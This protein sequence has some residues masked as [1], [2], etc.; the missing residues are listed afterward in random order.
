MDSPTPSLAQLTSKPNVQQHHN[1]SRQFLMKAE[2]KE[3]DKTSGQYQTQS[4]VEMPCIKSEQ[5]DQVQPETTRVAALEARKASLQT[6]FDLPKSPKSQDKQMN[7]HDVMYE[8]ETKV[9]LAEALECISFL[10]EYAKRKDQEIEKLRNVVLQIEKEKE[11]DRKGKK[12]AE[13]DE[14]GEKKKGTSMFLLT[15]NDASDEVDVSEDSDDSDGIY[16][17]TNE[18]EEDVVPLKT[19]LKIASSEGIGSCS[20]TG[21]GSGDDMIRS[22]TGMDCGLSNG[23]VEKLSML[24][25]ITSPGPNYNK[26]SKLVMSGES[27][28]SS[29][30]TGLPSD[31][32]KSKSTTDTPEIVKL[33]ENEAKIMHRKR[34]WDICF[35]SEEDMLCSLTSKPEMLLEA[36][37]ALSRLETKKRFWRSKG[38]HCKGLSDSDYQKLMDMA[39]FLM[40]GDLDCPNKKTNEELE[41]NFKGGLD[42]CAELVGT[43]SPQLYQIFSKRFD[44][45]FC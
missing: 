22:K 34:K 31:P 36:V 14:G 27:G 25:E 43:Y 15:I 4:T 21:S 35:G 7:S 41:K 32:M 26:R 20:K 39:K 38:M 1:T 9:Q 28:S 5:S 33:N 16:F 6:E 19:F 10:L 44:L 24:D 17:L 2:I 3:E 42:F 18:E 13:V 23:E 37:C 12:V 29:C 11:I 30:Q 8:N 40:E 45:H